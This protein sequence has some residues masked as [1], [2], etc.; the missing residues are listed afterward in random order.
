[1]EEGLAF[2]DALKTRAS[3][4]IRTHYKELLCPANEYENQEGY[5]QLI[6]ENVENALETQSFL[7]ACSTD[8]N[9]R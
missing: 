1:L 7:H 9:V 6:S 4:I 8:Q 3:G 5:W 2:L